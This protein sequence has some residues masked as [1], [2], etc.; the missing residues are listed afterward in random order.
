MYVLFAI[1]SSTVFALRSLYYLD[2]KKAILIFISND[3]GIE[4]YSDIYV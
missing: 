2:G 4:G 3:I 1:S